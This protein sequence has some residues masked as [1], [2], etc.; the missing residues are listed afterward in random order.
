MDENNFNKLIGY[1]IAI[2]IAYY[3]LGF[4]VPY[5]IYGVIG[6]VLFRVYQEYLKNKQ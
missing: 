2:I 5:L 3:I 4:V 1:A 6:L